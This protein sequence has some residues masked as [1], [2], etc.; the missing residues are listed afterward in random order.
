MGS[1]KR[2]KRNTLDGS[3]KDLKRITKRGSKSRNKSKRIFGKRWKI[4][5]KEELIK[6][7]EKN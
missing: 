6:N 7:A 5:F 1:S 3:K 4:E 2:L